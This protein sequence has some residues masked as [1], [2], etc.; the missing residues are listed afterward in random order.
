MIRF[1]YVE[2]EVRDH[3]RV[4]E[5]LGRLPKAEVIEVDRYQEVFNRRAQSF[6]LQKKQ[7]ALI[8][9]RKHDGF[10]LP[11]PAG[12]GIGGARNFYF[13]HM[14]NCL[15]DCRYCFLQGMYR[16]AHLVVFVNFEDFVGEIE[17]TVEKEPA[18][19][20]WFF[21]G[22]D[23]D[24]L[25]FDGVTGF[26][27]TFVPAL[28]RIPQAHLEL[29][30]KS[31]QVGGLLEREPHDRCV[32]AYSLSPEATAREL[33]HGAPSVARRLEAL[34]RLQQHGWPI[35]LRFDP[36]VY[37]PDAAERYRQLFE[38]VAST[39]DVDRVHS[40]S[41]GLFRLPQSFYRQLVKHYPEE[42]LL[43]RPMATEDGMTS[44]RDD[45]ARELRESCEQQLLEVFAEDVYFPCLSE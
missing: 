13:S 37:T 32:V 40:V 36:L 5:I 20:S 22:Y 26:A 29:R 30:T 12:Y 38:Q 27:D 16:S 45:L 10:V 35:G 3:P 42:P 11:T 28:E 1:A 14:M 39:I 24:S 21:S 44:Y 2:S 4:A 18:E 23:C 25:A 7:P 8:L 15:Y 31:V 9:A 33:E 17:K 34:S 19:A 41:L 43:A 6:R